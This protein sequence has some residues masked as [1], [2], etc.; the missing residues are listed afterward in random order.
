MTRQ[1]PSLET[2][3]FMKRRM[4]VENGNK[5]KRGHEY[6]H[7]L[8]EMYI[9][10]IEKG[11]RKLNKEKKSQKYSLTPLQLGVSK[12]F[13]NSCRWIPVMFPGQESLT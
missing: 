10:E 7:N 2:F 4:E 5:K 11:K 9:R 3:I 1:N 12:P 6:H 13:L 8:V